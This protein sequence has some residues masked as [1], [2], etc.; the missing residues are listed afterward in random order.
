VEAGVDK[1]VPEQHEADQNRPEDAVETG[2][3]GEEKNV[4]DPKSARPESDGH[5]HDGMR[6]QYSLQ[7][8]VSSSDLPLSPDFEDLA[9]SLTQPSQDAADIVV[10]EVT[11]DGVTKVSSLPQALSHGARAYELSSQA[12]STMFSLF[13][14]RMTEAAASDLPQAA[15]PSPNLNF[16]PEQPGKTLSEPPF[17]SYFAGQSKKTEPVEAARVNPAQGVVQKPIQGV[18]SASTQTSESGDASRILS[19]NPFIQMRPIAEPLS[20]PQPPATV[21]PHN[22]PSAPAAAQSSVETEKVKEKAD[23][24]STSS[25]APNFINSFLGFPLEQLSKTGSAARPA[26][27]VV[28]SHEKPSFTPQSLTDATKKNAS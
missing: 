8:D 3:V 17:S 19:L 20:S 4:P 15:P 23:T 26:N 9:A 7:E 11:E 27:T 21:V 28:S 25:S 1:T 14:G 2:Q 18:V 24:P 10:S 6:D 22:E 5:A 12:D 16:L 13:P